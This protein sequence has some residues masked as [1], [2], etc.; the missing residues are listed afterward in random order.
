MRALAIS[1]L[2]I[3]MGIGPA[4][5]QDGNFGMPPDAAQKARKYC[6][7]YSGGSF[8]SQAYCMDREKEGFDRLAPNYKNEAIVVD[9]ADEAR[10]S[11]VRAAAHYKD[12]ASINL[13]PPPYRMTE[14]NGCKR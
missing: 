2:A 7:K 13:C 11:A 10:K 3:L 6:S 8:S 12:P 14:R 5:A 9:L 4:V 1:L